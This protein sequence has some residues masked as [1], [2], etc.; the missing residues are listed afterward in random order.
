MKTNRYWAKATRTIRTQDRTKEIEL[1]VGSNDSPGGALQRADEVARAIQDRIDRKA[2]PDDYQ[3]E[4][5]EHVFESLG[6]RNVVTVNRY[7]ALVLNT[8]EYTI[9]DLDDYPFQFLDLFGAT[10]G[11]ARKELILERFRRRR[12]RHPSLGDDFR[13][14]ETTKGLRVIGKRHLSPR[15][16]GFRKT[17]AHLGVDTF[18]TF[19]CTRQ[20]CYRARLTPKP[21]R[22]PDFRTFRVRSPLDCLTPEFQTW[23]QE[24]LRHSRS[25]SSTHF[26]EAIG[27]D[28]S[29]DPVIQ[30][31]DRLSG[32]R[33]AHRLA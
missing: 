26:L 32:A 30:Y 16:K 19:M 2:K 20:D 24:Y 29:T 6:E 27:S 15:D 22:L 31:H 28:F 18:Y 21:Y 9:L 12:L 1:L 3:A 17:M 4:I 10:R 23:N 5:R 8:T 13:I 33:E 14:Y 25:C 7:G 11:R